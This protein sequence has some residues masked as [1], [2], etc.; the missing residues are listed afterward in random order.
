MRELFVYYRVPSIDALA[1]QALVHGFHERLLS[2]HPHLNARLLCRSDEADE[3]DETGAWQTWME[4]YS[5]DP[6]R[7][8]AGITAEI[9]SDIEAHARV[10]LPLID[11]PRHTEVFIACAS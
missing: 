2:L 6:M 8:P 5:T 1:A 7:E 11:G 4:T 10:L 3:A 9:Q